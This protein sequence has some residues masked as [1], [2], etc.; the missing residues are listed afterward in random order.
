MKVSKIELKIPDPCLE[1]M[2]SVEVYPPSEHFE[3]LDLKKLPALLESRA[4]L[5]NVPGSACVLYKKAK[6]ELNSL[7]FCLE[8]KAFF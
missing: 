8:F 6:R 3:L 4:L 2:V 5:C 7:L 1:N